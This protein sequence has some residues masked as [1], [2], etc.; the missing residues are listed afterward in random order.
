LP[1]NENECVV[2]KAFLTSNNKQIG[3]TIQVEIEDTTN[4]EGE[5]LAYLKHKEMKIVGTVQSPLYISRDRGTSKLGAGKVNYYIY[6]PEENIN[7][8]DI[9]TNIYVQVKDAREYTTS[10]DEYEDYIEEVTDSIEE[11]KAER[12]QSRHKQ[13]VD[14]A[15][16]KVM[17]AENELN[18]QKAETQQK[19]DDAE[20]EI[21]DGKKSNTNSRGRSK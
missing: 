19:I 7:A 21:E 3:D 2:E 10:S 18:T 16:Q 4:D 1:Q 20:K 11:M 12:E 9:Y 8:K 6:I 17:D 5:K 14:I 15:T 13:L